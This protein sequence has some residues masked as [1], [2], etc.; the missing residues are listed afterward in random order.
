MLLDTVLGIIILVQLILLGVLLRR[1]ERAST[2]R[3]L[4]Q[5]QQENLEQMRQQLEQEKAQLLTTYKSQFETLATEILNKQTQLFKQGNKEEMAHIVTPLSEKL[6]EFQAKVENFS[7]THHADQTSFN[8]KIRKIEDVATQFISS[9]RPPSG[10]RAW[11]ENTLRELLESMHFQKGVTYFEQVTHDDKRPDFLVRLPDNRLVV[12]DAK[13]IYA[14]YDT[15][16]HTANVTEQAKHLKAH[17]A[18]IRTTISSLH[19]KQYEKAVAEFCRSLQLP[20][21]E[22]PIDLVLMFVNPEGA[23]TAALQADSSILE[24]AQEKKVVLVSVSTLVGALTLIHTLWV[25]NKAQEDY[26]QMTHLAEEL[27][28]GFGQFLVASATAADALEKAQEAHQKTVALIN[29]EKDGLLKNAQQLADLSPSKIAA[30]NIDFLAKHG[31]T[32]TGEEKQ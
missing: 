16:M 11:G 1:Y 7:Q 13:T 8:E 24:L 17:V 29:D 19:K 18:K 28:G 10:A 21:D 20:E 23:L 22:C 31:Y 2:E 12:I 6:K 4:A 5:A 32:Y 30:T 26:E 3:A 27:V 15:Y 25:N 9:L 14:D